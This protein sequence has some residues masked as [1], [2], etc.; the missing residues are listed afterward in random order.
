VAGAPAEVT[1][2]DSAGIGCGDEALRQVERLVD[3]R[4]RRCRVLAHVVEDRALGPRGDDRPVDPLDPDV[5]AA[6]VATL[7]T[8]QRFER[9]DLVGASELAESEEDHPGL[10]RHGVIIR[11]RRPRGERGRESR[12]GRGV[13]RVCE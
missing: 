6:P 7:I 9:V 4:G 10:D 12:C 2:V 5:G 8:P 11:F 3:D 13:H 1:E